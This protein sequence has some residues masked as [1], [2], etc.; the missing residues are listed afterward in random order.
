MTLIWK[1]KLNYVKYDINY[2]CYNSKTEL[3]IILLNFLKF[4]SKFLR[5]IY[6]QSSMSPGSAKEGLTFTDQRLFCLQMC[7]KTRITVKFQ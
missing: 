7:H 2:V 3:Q 6:D 4:V 1:A 5:V